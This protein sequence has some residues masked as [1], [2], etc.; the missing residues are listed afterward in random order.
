MG[1]K[2]AERSG[3]MKAIL[4][5][6]NKVAE[7]KAT[8]ERL[9][10]DTEKAIKICDVKNEFGHIVKEMYLSPTGII[11]SK[12]TKPEGLYVEDQKAAE[13][14]IGKNHPEIYIRFFGPVK[15]A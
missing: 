13:E 4:T 5:V 1:R 3:T 10:F 9:L 12:Y 15:E 7:D 2:G 6:K 11:F 14:Y 8:E